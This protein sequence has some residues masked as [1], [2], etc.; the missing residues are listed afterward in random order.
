MTS[1]RAAPDPSQHSHVCMKAGPI[2]DYR[3]VPDFKTNKMVKASSRDVHNWSSQSINPKLLNER[4][5]YN[6]TV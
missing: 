6:T 5:K 1:G 4:E 3:D 2:F